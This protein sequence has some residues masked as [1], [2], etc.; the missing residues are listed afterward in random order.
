MANTQNLKKG[1]P[2]TQFESGQQAV[3]SGRKGGIASGIAKRERKAMKDTLGALLTMSIKE[4]VTTDIES[5]QSIAA[6]N[7]KNITVQEA[8]MLAQIQKAIKGDT[9]AAE[10]IRDTSGNKLKEALELTGSVNN[11]FAGLTT[12]ELKKLAGDE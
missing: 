11:P 5:I 9:K 1:N 6:L 7:G 2:E 3:E 12:E 10:Y 8:I 4:G